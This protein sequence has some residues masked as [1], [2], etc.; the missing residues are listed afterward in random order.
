M[1]ASAFHGIYPILYAFFRADG[2]LDR[3]AMRRQVEACVRGGAQGIA[4][5]GLATEVQKLSPEER[6]EV[7]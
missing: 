7:M 5:L 3:E 4:A 2:G 1:A 6:H